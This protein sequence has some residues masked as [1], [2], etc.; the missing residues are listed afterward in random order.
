MVGFFAQALLFLKDSTSQ[1]HQAHM[2][3]SLYFETREEKTLLLSPSTCSR[4]S[5]VL[6]KNHAEKNR[7]NTMRAVLPNCRSPPD[8]RGYPSPLQPPSSQLRFPSRGWTFG[9]LCPPHTLMSDT[10]SPRRCSIQA[11]QPCSPSPTPRR[12]QVPWNSFRA[13]RAPS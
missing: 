6:F 4:Y 8:A 13:P 9:W 2:R 1:E 12:Q 10:L 5:L 7:A 3:P 11:A